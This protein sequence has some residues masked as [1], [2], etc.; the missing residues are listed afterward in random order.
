MA[1]QS[2]DDTSRV[3][4]ARWIVPVNAPPIH[5]GWIRVQ[6]QRIVE[7]GSNSVPSGAHDLGDV[8]VLPGLVNA[9]THLEFSD[10]VLPVGDPG[11]PLAK[12]IGEVI[13]ARSRLAGDRQLARES[14]IQ[15]GLA[16]SAECGVRL[17]GE[18]ATP[19]CNYEPV[20]DFPSVE[21][22]SFAEVLG[23]SPVRFT[24]RLDAA[25][26]HNDEYD[27]AAWSPH[28]PYSTSRS[29][30]EVVVSQSCRSGRPLAMHVAESPAER[31]LLCF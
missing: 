20:G 22:I 26:A 8:A 25:V 12:W 31:E 1:L 14:G 18:I 16:E 10:C 27:H 24:E 30:I 15:L 21:L 13:V 2:S 9:H 17:L 3:L 29:A 28:A 6:G 5:G 7:I 19:P 11:M 4:S 23:L